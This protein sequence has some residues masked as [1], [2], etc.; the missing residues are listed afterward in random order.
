MK[1]VLIYSLKVWL[2]SVLLGP[3][4]YYPAQIIIEP[5]YPHQFHYDVKYG[6]I[7]SLP[8]LVVAIITVVLIK[9]IPTTLTVKKLLLSIVGV[10]LTA[11]PFYLLKGGWVQQGTE[12]LIAYGSIIVIGIWVYRLEPMVNNNTTDI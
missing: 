1:Q 12:Y 9:P 11:M 10:V 8:S 3:L 7:F 6:F 4:L 5:Q 2:T